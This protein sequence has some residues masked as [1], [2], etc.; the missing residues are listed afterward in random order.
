MPYLN[1]YL[2]RDRIKALTDLIGTTEFYAIAL[3]G[4]GALSSRIQ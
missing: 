1:S 2:S 3:G 4:R